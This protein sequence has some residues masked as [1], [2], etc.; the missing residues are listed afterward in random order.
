MIDDRSQR[1]PNGIGDAIDKLLHESKGKDTIAVSDALE[2]FGQRSFGPL[3]LVLA[4]LLTLPTG[5]L[6]GVPLALG[7][8][9]QAS[10]ST[11]AVRAISASSF[12]EDL[13][14]WGSLLVPLIVGRAVNKKLAALPPGT[15]NGLTNKQR[16]LL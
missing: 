15:F 14:T 9:F 12:R 5:A 3:I 10:I 13:S 7:G 2:A 6:P 11:R 16:A 4:I 8:L 1:A